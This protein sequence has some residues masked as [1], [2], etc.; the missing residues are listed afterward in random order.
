M[1]HF[2]LIYVIFSGLICTGAATS[3]EEYTS[4]KRTVELVAIN[5]ISGWL[6]LPMLIGKFL[7]K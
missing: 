3:E 5:L 4:V 6:F 1:L 2:I 7:N